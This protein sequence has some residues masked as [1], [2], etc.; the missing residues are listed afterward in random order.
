[1]NQKSILNSVTNDNLTHPLSEKSKHYYEENNIYEIFSIAEDYPNKIFE[2]LYPN[3]KNKIVLDLGC[4]TGKFMQKFYKHTT[5]YYGLDQSEN[6]L[7]IAKSKVN[8]DN[9]EFI[10]CSAEKIPLPDNS[11]DIIIS[12]WVLGT[13][14]EDD[15]RIKAIEEM[16][17][18]VKKD[19]S[20]YLVEND[21]GGE[22]EAIRDRYPDVTETKEYNDWLENYGFVCNSKFETFFEFENINQAKRVFSD[23]FGTEVGN[24]IKNNTIKHNVIIYK[25]KK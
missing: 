11:I 23:I 20:I 13:I 9:V 1:M 24:K 14:L 7:E 19:G 4:G 3:I 21:I 10:C 15:R 6:Q 18:V 8:G 16:K 25:L 22:F 5:K 2:H 17:R 12:T